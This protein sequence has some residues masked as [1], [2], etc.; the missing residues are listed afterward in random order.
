MS[1]RIYI[2]VQSHRHTSVVA[3][4]SDGYRVA[5]NMSTDYHTTVQRTNQ[6]DSVSVLSSLLMFR[7]KFGYLT[8]VS[9]YKYYRFLSY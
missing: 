3:V 1:K 8:T 4:C 5:Y 7:F 2:I 6:D 9:R